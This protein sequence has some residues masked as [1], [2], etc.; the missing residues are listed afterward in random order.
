MTA[1]K[2]EACDLTIALAGN[3]NVGKTTVFNGLTGQR[4]HTGN[5]IGKTVTVA[6]GTA[7]H[8]GRA[9]RLVDLP[10]CYSLSARSAEEAVARDFI[11]FSPHDATVVVCDATCL[12]RN[13]MLALQIA[14]VEPC[15]VVCVNLLDAAA[16]SGITVDLAALS[17]ELGIPVVGVSATRK[18]TLSALLYSTVR[19]PAR[20][21]LRE[22]VNYGAQ[23]EEVLQPL[24]DLL[25]QQ[26]KDLRAPRFWA[27]R[28]LENDTA[29][30]DRM[31]GGVDDTLAEAA[32]AGRATLAAQGIEEAALCDAVTLAQLR[33][34]NEIA[35]RVTT[36]SGAG[37]A[38]TCAVDRVLTGRRTAFPFMLLLLSVVLFLTVIAANLPSEGLSRLF[39]AM[40]SGGRR[41][42]EAIGLP[43]TLI[44]LLIDG[45]WSVLGTVVA[46]MLPPML[47]FFTLFTL[48]E[49]VGYLPRVAYDLDR[50]LCRCRH[51]AHR[52]PLPHLR[53]RFFEKR[54]AP[55]CHGPLAQR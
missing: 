46:V 40:G 33:R 11:C 55:H 12:A 4:Q 42:L 19:A 16:R 2:H 44:G 23:I 21:L 13:L 26:R 50:P 25:A 9:L 51:R 10:G 45:I 34:A 43:P 37:R 8:E 29:L 48:L 24:A 1:R 32:A 47:I 3:P 14:E 39:A 22:S 54:F 38:A 28:L 36:V 52:Y 5:W 17:R 15:T 7:K 41:A 49:D 53:T 20:P 31:P 27:L 30:T 35:E 18:Q 6:Q